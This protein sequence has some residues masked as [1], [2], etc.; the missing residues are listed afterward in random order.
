MLDSLIT[1]DA[2]IR[3]ASITYKDSSKEMDRHSKERPPSVPSTS[4]ARQQQAFGQW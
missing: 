2:F 3:C 4:H 1:I